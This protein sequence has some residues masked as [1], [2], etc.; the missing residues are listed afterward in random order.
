MNRRRDYTG[1]ESM[2][3]QNMLEDDRSRENGQHGHCPHSTRLLYYKEINFH[4]CLMPC[5]R[6]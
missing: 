1:T 2:A 6:A 3:V 4:G 5:Q